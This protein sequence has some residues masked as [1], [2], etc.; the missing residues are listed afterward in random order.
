M[1]LGNQQ[2]K[3]LLNW[4][5]FIIIFYLFTCISEAFSKKYLL[6]KYYHWTAHCMRR[7]VLAT[8]KQIN[9]QWLV[10]LT[11]LL[12][13]IWMMH[14]QYYTVLAKFISTKHNSLSNSGL[15][16][17][18]VPNLR[19]HT[20]IYCTV[21]RVQSVDTVLYVKPYMWCLKWYYKY[22]LFLVALM[23]DHICIWWNIHNTTHFIHLWYYKVHSIIYNNN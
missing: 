18:T 1:P 2:Y 22:N 19:R 5:G 7:N 6:P 8:Q 23:K 13:I 9:R 15:T 4:R 10:I 14:V 16:C 12:S 3:F 21:C 17:C 11:I 20:L